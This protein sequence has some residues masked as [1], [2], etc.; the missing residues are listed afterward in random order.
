[1][2]EVDLIDMEAADNV[3]LQ[4][5][6]EAVALGLEAYTTQTDYALHIVTTTSLDGTPSGCVVGFLTQCSIVPPRFLVCISKLNHTYFAVERSDT[7]V[8]HL[9]ARTQTRLAS[10]FGEETGDT[11]DKFSRCHWG[12]GVTGSPVLSGCAAWIEGAII[13]RWSVGDHQALLV[14]PVAGG[15]DN[16]HADVLTYQSS[17]DFRPGHPTE[18]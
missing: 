6:A 5:D 8:L 2:Q 18:A 12:A 17:P 1:M 14:R 10:L 11:I 15:S 9:I 7:I 3:Y 13:D 4:E 16:Q